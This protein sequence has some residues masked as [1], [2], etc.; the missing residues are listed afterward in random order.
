MANEI[1][2]V[3]QLKLVNGYN[4]FNF[5]VGSI[6][7]TQQNPGGPIPGVKLISFSGET[8]VSLADLTDSGLCVIHNTDATNFIN[9][10]FTT[11]QLKAKL[12]PNEAA[13]LRLDEATSQLIM[14]ADTADCLVAVYA[15]EN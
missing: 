4:R 1:I 10:G 14:Q 15:F 6:P 8:T 5:N 9:W 13:I 3:P 11:A 12:L 2:Y 7:V